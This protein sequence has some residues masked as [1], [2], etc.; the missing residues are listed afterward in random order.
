MP[1]EMAVEEGLFD[2][3]SDPG[4]RLCAPG[5]H[6]EPEQPHRTC[7]RRNQAEERSDQ[8]RLPGAVRTEVAERDAAWDPEIDPLDDAALT[9]V[10]AE[11]VGLDHEGR[12]G[13]RKITRLN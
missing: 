1:G 9:E 8:R 3:R 13:D 11:P 6:R 2:D 12:D 5:R 4:Q 7:R 10:L